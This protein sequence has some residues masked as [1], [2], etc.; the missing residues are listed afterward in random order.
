MISKKFKIGLKLFSTNKQYVDEAKR[1]YDSGLYSYIELYSVPYSYNECISYWKGVNIPFI[2][3]APHFGGGLNL[4]DWSKEK[5]NEK[6]LREAYIYAD[7]LNSNDIIVHPGVKGELAS[8]IEQLKLFYDNR[9]VIENKPFCSVDKRWT[10]I[11]ATIEDI[12]SITSQTGARFCLD[13]G[14]AICAANFL[15]IEP[16]DYIKQFIELNPYMFHISDGNYS[17][18][19]DSHKHFGAGTFP[20][21]E[22][23]SLFPYDSIVTI[24]TEKSFKDNLSD[25]V[26]DLD[27]FK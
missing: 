11:G 3:H 23:I 25:F 12:E 22:I 20:I 15:K 24:E 26:L 21:K 14:H 9:I 19:R 27:Y 5:N 4:G 16:K 1:L 17:D 18:V 6:L 10:C 8:T 2:I 7:S 13:I